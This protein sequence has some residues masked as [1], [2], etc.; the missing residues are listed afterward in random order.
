[1]NLINSLLNSLPLCWLSYHLGKLTDVRCRWFK[2]FLIN[3]FI[4]FYRIDLS[5]CKYQDL[6]QFQNFND[7][8]AR[9]LAPGKRDF[10]P[11]KIVLFHLLMVL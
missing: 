2:N 11:K 9:E 3:N 1:M 10:S 8:F 6:N 7:F 4:R 5:E